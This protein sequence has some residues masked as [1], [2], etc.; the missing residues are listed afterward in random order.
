MERLEGYESEG[1]RSFAGLSCRFFVGC[2]RRVGSGGWC[3]GGGGERRAYS[4][5]GGETRGLASVSAV[6]GGKCGV[7]S[8]RRRGRPGG[9][10]RGFDDGVLGEERNKIL[11]REAL[12][13]PRDQRTDD[14]ADGGA[15]SAGCDRPAS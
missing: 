8:C 1:K 3:D 15:V 13:E 2:Q 11:S 6:Q 5:D 10:L 4:D 14:G 12:C 7:G 9:L